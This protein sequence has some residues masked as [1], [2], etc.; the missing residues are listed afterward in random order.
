MQFFFTVRINYMTL[1][2]WVLLTQIQCPSGG[3]I[4]TSLLLHPTIF[5]GA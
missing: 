4:I 1:V 5:G 3:N 2:Q